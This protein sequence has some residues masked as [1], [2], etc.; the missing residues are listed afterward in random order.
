MAS[1]HVIVVD[2]LDDAAIADVRRIE[3][4][5]SRYRDDSVTT[6]INRASGGAPV[7]IDAETAAL[8]DFADRCHRL[9]AGHFDVTSGVPLLAGPA[10][11][12][13]RCRWPAAGH[14]RKVGSDSTFVSSGMLE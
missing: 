7:A 9:S 8:V 2:G 5:Y 1:D 10:V 6:A 12:R 3:A 14:P 13:R 4:K 11:A